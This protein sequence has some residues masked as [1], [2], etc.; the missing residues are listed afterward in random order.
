M[1]IKA[2][3]EK[4]VNFALRMMEIG[5]KFS[6][7]RKAFSEFVNELGFDAWHCHD[8]WVM[9]N[10]QSGRFVINKKIIDITWIESHNDSHSSF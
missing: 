6:M 4:G 9:F 10:N 8:G 1:E 3:T 5:R 2:N 7:A